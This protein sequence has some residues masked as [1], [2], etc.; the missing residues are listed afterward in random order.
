MR[1]DVLTTEQQALL[2]IVRN[3]WIAHGLSTAP[4]D[5]PAAEA[6]IILAYERAGLAAPTRVV[7]CTSPLALA[8][9]D[10]ILRDPKAM[11]SVGASVGAS[12]GDSVRASV[13]AS[14]WASVWDSVNAQYE[15]HWLAFYAVFRRMGLDTS[16]L[17]GLLALNKSA[18]WWIARA[19][20]A[21]IAERPVCLHRDDRGRLHCETGPSVAWSD[22]WGVYSWHGATVPAE[23]ITQRATLDPTI[24]LTH[25]NADLRSTAAE[26]IG[27]QKVINHLS[28]RVIHTDADPMIGTLLAATIPGEPGE[29]CF[30]R[31]RCGT[32][33]DVVVPVTADP[34]PAPAGHGGTAR[35]AAAWSYNMTEAEYN[36]E[37]RT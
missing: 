12:V 37:C 9:V 23:W 29:R 11:D 6:A 15:S 17:D 25:P 4:T 18:G 35:G 32:G 34:S 20:I 30:L 26:I 16:K 27:W 21:L 13:G 1:I 33:R 19:N 10:S 7:R 3:E 28:P 36:P 22:G 31:A 14:V 5:W 24:A 2:P 8:F